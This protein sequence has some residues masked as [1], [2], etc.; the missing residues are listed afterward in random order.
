[1]HNELPDDVVEQ[2]RSRDTRFAM[3]AQAIAVETDLRDNVTI[4]SLMDAVRAD[5]EQAMR[6]IVE[7][8]PADVQAIA[9]HQVRIR[10]LTYI[11]GVLDAIMRRG[12]YAEHDLRTE[13]Q[14]DA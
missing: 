3:L 4:R 10:T 11:R 13:E 9:L 5:A 8:S 12:A 1:M 7:V 6:D 14:L 2:A